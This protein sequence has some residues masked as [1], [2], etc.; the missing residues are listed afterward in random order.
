MKYPQTQ[1]NELK[2]ALVV[3]KNRYQID[4][5][6]ATANASR[7]YFKVYQQ[8]NYTSENLNVIKNEDGARL[9]ELNEGFRLYPD[10]CNEAHVNTA[11][12]NIIK[13]IF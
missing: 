6:T 4:K 2:S 3:L 9:F 13:E 8:K 10:G 1:Y 11:M 5:E 7:L 12:K